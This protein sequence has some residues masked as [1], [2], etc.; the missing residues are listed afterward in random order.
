MAR[1]RITPYIILVVAAA[2]SGFLYGARKNGLFA[3]QA[4]DRAANQY[5]GLCDV[6]NFGDY[7]HGAFWFGLESAAVEAASA[8]DVLFLG[9]S[10]MQFGLSTGVLGSWFDE[11]GISFYLMGFSHHDNYLFAKPLLRKINPAAT[12]Y[13]VN[14]DN[15]F[16]QQLTGPANAVMNEP[17]ALNRYKQKYYWQKAHQLLCGSI[18]WVCGNGLSF[19][20]ERSRGEWIFGGADFLAA[21]DFSNQRLAYDSSVDKELVD[22]YE[23]PA[24]AFLST[25]TSQPNCIV[26]TNIPNFDISAGTAQA[27]S[28]RL[29]LPLVDP[30]LSGLITF[31]GS[32]LDTDS[33]SI[34]A[35]A[36][37]DQLAPHIGKC[38]QTGTQ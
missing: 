9:N 36:F 22:R 18:A 29:G 13:V 11:Q 19:I 27:L 31:D 7:D 5:V 15:F 4:P 10:R 16:E 32:H 14:I 37:V 30:R 20:R 6:L 25:L 17:D 26:L 12:M 2:I 33:A 3:C 1:S 21:S 8:A 24:A 23:V 38:F 34:W 35:T 28:D